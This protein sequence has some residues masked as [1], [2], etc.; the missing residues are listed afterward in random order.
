MRYQPRLGN[1][2]L[3]KLSWS[4]A[5]FRWTNPGMWPLDDNTTERDCY[6]DQAIVV[7]GFLA[8]C[9]QVQ[10]GIHYLFN[11]YRD[12]DNFFAALSPAL[13]QTELIIRFIHLAMHKDPLKKLLKYFYSEI[14]VSQE[15]DQRSFRRINRQLLGPKLITIFY[16]AT[17]L[18]YFYE[19]GMNI[20]AGR[21]EM[22]FKQ[23]YFFDHRK[24]PIYIILIS[25]NFWASL[26]I[27]T[28]VFVD[29]NLLGE[30]LMHLNVC[31]LQLEK[32]LR[33]AAELLL[34]SNKTKNIAAKYGEEL[35]KVLS[36]N[37][38]LNHFAKEI[39]K[40]FTFRLFI[41][42]SFSSVILCVLLFKSYQNPAEN[43][44]FIF[45]FIAKFI[46]QLSF[47]YI[48]SILYQTTN[49]LDMMYYCGEWEQI[50]YSSHNIEENVKLM[51]LIVLSMQLNSKPFS[52]T[53][54]N[55]FR[56]TLQAIVKILQGAFSYFTFLAS[57]R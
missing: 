19:F 12:M 4:L 17:L 34:G 11:N 1:G 10:G 57:M 47:G 16:M 6:L 26:L 48:G 8:F 44:I 42:F 55:Y 38:S 20:M 41:T 52:L 36:R 25:I 2:E 46:E 30:L 31:Y 3:V 18:N 35:I 14:Y 40:Q 45:W 49:A 9:I 32:D 15:S 53:G 21:R 39:E 13:L 7:S 56:V 33:S 23:A 5:L 51:K 27:V 50:I 37:I 22:L 29:L 28:M 24:L 43:M 54:L